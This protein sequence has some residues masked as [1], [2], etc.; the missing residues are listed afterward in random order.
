MAAAT[1]RKT[2]GA[3]WGYYYVTRLGFC[4]A[5]LY[6]VGFIPNPAQ[7]EDCVDWETICRTAS[8]MAEAI[9]QSVPAN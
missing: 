7:Y 4:P 9:L 5:V 6:E 8:G 1:G 2:D 3:E